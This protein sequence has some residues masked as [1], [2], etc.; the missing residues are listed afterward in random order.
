MKALR[1]DLA[2][3][4]IIIGV[5]SLVLIASVLV[6]KAA[7][8]YLPE[9]NSRTTAEAITASGLPGGFSSFY[10]LFQGSSL[11]RTDTE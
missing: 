3:F 11:P 5:F 7:R 6:E 1:K 2:A 9:R 4:T 10:L 8:E